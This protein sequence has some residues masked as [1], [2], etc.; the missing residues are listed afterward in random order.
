MN[1]TIARTALVMIREAYPQGENM[2]THPAEALEHLEPSAEFQCSECWGA[3]ADEHVARR[4]EAEN[5]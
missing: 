1:V 2:C 3:V 5:R 4:V